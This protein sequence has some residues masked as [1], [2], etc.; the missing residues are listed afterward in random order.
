MRLVLD[1]CVIVSA[2]RSPRG[3]SFRLLDLINQDRY[4]ILATSPLFLESEAVLKR[5]EQV[6]V[7][8]LSFQQL[9]AALDDLASHIHEVRIAFDW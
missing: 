9:D 5:P 3:A 8:C 1:T 2:F 6:A 4:T 7:H